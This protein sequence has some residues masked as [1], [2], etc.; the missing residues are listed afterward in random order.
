MNSSKTDAKRLL[1]DV[2]QVSKTY[3]LEVSPG[4]LFLEGLFG[5]KPKRDVLTALH[6]LD[7][8]VSQ[9][10][11]V[12]I[13][14]RNGAGK[15]TL[16]SI[17]AGVQAPT[18]GTV[19]RHGR[20]AALIG[21]GQ[22]FNVEETGRY[23]AHNF[24]RVLGLTKAAALEAVEKICQ[25]SEL[26]DYFERPVKTYSSG[27]KARLN[28]SCATFVEAD[29]IIIDE[30]LAVGD[31][32]FRS[33]CYA[34]IEAC[35]AAGQTYLMVSHAPAVIGNYCDKVLVLNK[36]KL[37]F[38]GDPLGGM[39]TYKDMVSVTD[40]KRRTDT[41]LM[42][43]RAQHADASD[44]GNWVEIV[45]YQL[46]DENSEV[47][48]GEASDIYMEAANQQITM[49]VR[50]RINRDI[51]KP[52]L[53][54]GWRNTKGLMVGV[55]TKVLQNES[56]YKGDIREVI[57]EFKARLVVGRYSLRFAVGHIENREKIQLLER[58][59]LIELEVVEGH[60]AGLVDLDFNLRSTQLVE[61]DSP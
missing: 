57:F 32:E 31:A 18:T 21:I 47:P 28:F 12:G 52:R 4:R 34:H 44:T 15:S 16:L 41:E 49:R 29:L 60:R 33:K 53:A 50:L 38:E 3:D 14:G 56:W 45:A 27:M 54:A 23:N 59:N 22:S 11:S 43:L 46:I 37:V 51:P 17:L 61:L 2:S 5:A 48:V 9:G 6:P 19:T 35:L 58:E 42:Q 25:F 26:G 1:L 30:V 55:T 36:G 7:L 39:Q 24:C 10:E 13:L 40:R 20:I 8:Q